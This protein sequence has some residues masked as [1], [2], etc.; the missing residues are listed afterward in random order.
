MTTKDR[1]L[2]QVIALMR[3]DEV[4]NTGTKQKLVTTAGTCKVS[5]LINFDGASLAEFLLTTDPTLTD[6]CDL[7]TV[8]E[9]LLQ[10]FG[11]AATTAGTSSPATQAVDQAIKVQVELPRNVG[12]MSLR[13]LLELLRSNPDRADEILAYVQVQP[14]VARACRKSERLAI[15]RDGQLDVEATL[16]Y[17]T[18]VARD[19]TQLSEL[20]EG[21][22]PTTFAKAAGT[23]SRP[24]I[25]PFT[26]EPVEGADEL[27]FDFSAL[28]EELHNALLWASVTRHPAWP[29]TIDRFTMSQEVFETTL[30]RRWQLILDAYRAAK[31]DNDEVATRINRYYPKELM[32]SLGLA[33]PSGSR[34]PFGHESKRTPE[35]YEEQLRAIA[36]APISV[37]GSNVHRRQCVLTSVSTQ[38]GNIHLGDVILLGRAVTTGG[39]LSGK[40]CMPTG[41]GAHTVGGD[42]NLQAYNFSWKKLYEKAVELGL[43]DV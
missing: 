41:V 36:E 39:N 24:Y 14:Q 30:P 32:R 12:D 5:D 42:N 7:L 29:A 13:E 25:H 18:H 28:N 34:H 31:A 40:A 38:G 21:V 4:M 1:T 23:D 22:R 11:Q 2:Q 35:W 37:I 43:I 8:S 10:A 26:G 27:G 17:I 33:G 3:T 9:R 6:T 15:L 20:F 16:R 19:Y